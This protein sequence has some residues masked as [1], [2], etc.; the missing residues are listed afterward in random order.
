MAALFMIG[1]TEEI[2]NRLDWGF[3]WDEEEDEA[4]WEKIFKET[5]KNIIGN[6]PIMGALIYA[7]ETGR[8]FTPAPVY[9]SLLKI[10]LNLSRG[11]FGDAAWEGTGFI[12]MPNA[13]Q[14]VIKGT[15]I[16]K[17]GGVYDKTGRLMYPVEGTP[18]QIRTLLKG[19][20]GS[21]TARDYWEEKKPK[22]KTK[23]EKRKEKAKAERRKKIERMRG[24]YKRRTGASSKAERKKKIE[25]W[26]SSK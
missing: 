24:L 12:Y 16:I 1:Y 7:L 2:I 15:K 23:A 19:K 4:D 25:K 14:N 21:K 11:K 9:A 8:P 13:V 5:T 3:G 26:R 17:E 6:V 22:P 20:Y 18:E 10:I